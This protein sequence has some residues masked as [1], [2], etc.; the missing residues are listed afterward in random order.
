MHSFPI[1]SFKLHWWFFSVNSE[2]ICKCPY[3]N[4]RRPVPT[5]NYSHQEDRVRA[6]IPRNI[7]D[8]VNDEEDL[9]T[10]EQ[11]MT[12][13]RIEGIEVLVEQLSK[14]V[15]ELNSKVLKIYNLFIASSYF[16]VQYRL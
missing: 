2:F 6:W 3:L 11:D 12:E 9:G 10:Y 15:L 14:T 4:A 8:E 5:P 1:Y 13:Q 16:R 7:N